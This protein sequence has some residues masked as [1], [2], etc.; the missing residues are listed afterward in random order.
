VPPEEFERFII[1]EH[2]EEE[3]QDE[4]PGQMRPAPLVNWSPKNRT[5]KDEE[6]NRQWDGFLFFWK[7]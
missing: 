6:G 4:S 2:D 1:R 3:I 7:R 5:G